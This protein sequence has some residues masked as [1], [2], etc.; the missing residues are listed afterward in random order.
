MN[1]ISLILITKNESENIKK[2]QTWL[3]KIKNVNELILVDDNSTDNT[4]DE[5]KKL[6][7]NHLTI[8]IFKRGLV[9]NFSDQRQFA[10]SKTSND[11]ILWLDADEQPSNELITYINNI[12]NHLYYNYAFK[13]QDIFLGHILK[14]GETSSQYFLRLFN[15]NYGYFSGTVHEL[16]VSSNT[17]KF[18]D[19]NIIHISHQ[20]LKSFYEKIN[21]Y[22]SLRAQ[23][24]FK[25]KQRTNLFQI[26][27][28]P[29]GKF[30]YNYYIRLGFLDG[31]PGIIIAIGMSFHSF[32]VRGKL[33]HL[34]NS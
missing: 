30:I 2:W 20:S 26:I 23:E 28:F 16:W 12:D 3:P 33:W 32:L 1:N 34:S 24:L 14:H 15:K 25:L 29:L 11:W 6:S 18:V 27:F 5:V 22:S 19:L 13:R 10:I 21:Y 8:K 9:H 31:T 7:T 17:T 4:I